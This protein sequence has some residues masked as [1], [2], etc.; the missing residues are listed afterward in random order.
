MYNIYK[1]VLYG[2]YWLADSTGESA[3]DSTEESAIK[4]F[5][6][7]GH[8]KEDW[9]FSTEVEEV[10]EIAGGWDEEEQ[11]ASTFVSTAIS[12]SRISF[13]MCASSPS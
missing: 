8:V 6:V 7:G 13:R 3:T 2:H 5:E 11:D 1:W 12:D 10:V 4:V 9:T